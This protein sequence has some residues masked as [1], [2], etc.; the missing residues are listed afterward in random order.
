MAIGLLLTGI[1]AILSGTAPRRM[2]SILA[3]DVCFAKV[4]QAFFIGQKTM[5]GHHVSGNRPWTYRVDVRL[6]NTL[7]T[8]IDKGLL[9]GDRLQQQFHSKKYRVCYTLHQ[10]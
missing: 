1:A 2:N 9:L 7:Q 5:G 6:N 4:I 3:F 8:H 10:R